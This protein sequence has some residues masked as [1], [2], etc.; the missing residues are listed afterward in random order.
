MKWRVDLVVVSS[1]GGGCTAVRV[2]VVVVGDGT[3]A[4]V[5]MVLLSITSFLD[6][7][8]LLPRK[9]FAIHLSCLQ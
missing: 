5:P 1:D 7:K 8:L 6:H 3:A 4:A 9:F 2:S